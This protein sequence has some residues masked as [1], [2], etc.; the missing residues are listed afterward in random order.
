MKLSRKYFVIGG[1]VLL[2]SGCA[3]SSPRAEVRPGPP[4]LTPVLRPR[5]IGPAVDRGVIA[6]NGLNVKANG[7]LGTVIGRQRWARGNPIIARLNPM[8]GVKRITVHHEGGTVVNFADVRSTSGRLELI[9]KA[10]LKC[11]KAGDIGYHYIIDR[12]G[13]LWQGRDMRFQG[14]H[15]SNHNE[16]NIGIMV[17]GNFDRQNPTSQQ[18]VTLQMTL[19]QL[20]GEY[21]IATHNVFTHQ[22]LTQTQCPG[23]VLQRHMADL[24]RQS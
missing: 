4:W 17:L 13:R 5:P 21:Q 19:Q 7:G 9:R 6:A 12:A 1:A 11:M 20:M 16:H 10:H 3:P 15:V 22:E 14:A 24:R 8:G 23:K 18:L 2:I